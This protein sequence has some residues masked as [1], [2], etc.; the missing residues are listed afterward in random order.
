MDLVPVLTFE[1]ELLSFYPEVWNNINNPDWL[2]LQP[3]EYQNKILPCLK[4][5]FFAVPKRFNDGSYDGDRYEYDFGTLFDQI[6]PK[7]HNLFHPSYIS[8]KRACLLILLEKKMLSTSTTIFLSMLIVS[9]TFC[10][11]VLVFT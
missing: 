9:G 3:L 7:L 2:K 11:F 6:L 8:N 10:M 4:K 5:N 1:P